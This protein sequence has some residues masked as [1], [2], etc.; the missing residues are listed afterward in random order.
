MP[1]A[2]TDKDWEPFRISDLIE[3]LKQAREAFGDDFEVRICVDDQMIGEPIMRLFIKDED[4]PP[5]VLLC[6]P[7]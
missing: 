4:E 6:G 1:T 7:E 2:E 3:L 5:A